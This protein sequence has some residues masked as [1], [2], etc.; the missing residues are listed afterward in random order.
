[1]HAAPS[2]TSSSKDQD[3]DGTELRRYMSIILTEKAVDQ[4]VK[5]MGEQ[6]LD[7]TRAYL[8]IHPDIARLRGWRR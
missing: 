5:V 6:G 7:K 8:R 3:G 4:L 2:E 1:M